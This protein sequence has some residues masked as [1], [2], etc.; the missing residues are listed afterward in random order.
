[1]SSADADYVTRA[2]HFPGQQSTS[3]QSKS[4]TTKLNS[5]EKKTKFE[6]ANFV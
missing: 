5:N 1:M 3:Q 6:F 2:L 4:N